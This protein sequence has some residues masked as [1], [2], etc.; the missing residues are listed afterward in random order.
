M[1]VERS[2][3]A[4]GFMFRVKMQ[5]YSRDFAPVSTLRV[6]VEQAQ[7][8]DEVLLVVN[9]QYGIG[10]RGIGDIGIKRRLLHG[11]PRNRLSP[12]TFA[13]AP[14]HID[15]REAVA[16]H[17]HRSLPDLRPANARS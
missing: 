5:H 11:R 15:D 16:P 6:R 8:R 17:S 14:W 2:P 12:S 3:S 10:G 1:A 9:G 13:L 4:I 7:I